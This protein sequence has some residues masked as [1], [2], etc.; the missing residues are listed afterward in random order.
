VEDH[1]SRLDAI[2]ALLGPG[3]ANLTEIHRRIDSL[4]K[5]VEKLK[6]DDAPPGETSA[7]ISALNEQR[8]ALNAIETLLGPSAQIRARVVPVLVPAAVGKQALR[9]RS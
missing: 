8:A 4:V 7:V 3:G 5:V 2:E 9:E 6:D 1:E